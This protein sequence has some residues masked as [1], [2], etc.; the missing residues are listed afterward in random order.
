MIKVFI[1]GGTTEG[2][3]LAESL[4]AYDIQIML[5]VASSY[6]KD[7]VSASDN[8]QIVVGHDW[9]NELHKFSQ[10]Q[11]IDTLFVFDATHPFASTM[12]KKI[13]SECN[14][15][16]LKLHRINRQKIDDSYL[17]SSNKGIKINDLIHFESMDEIV[18]WLN[19]VKG[20]IYSTLGVKA[21][22]K[23][24]EIN[25][26]EERITARILSRLESLE[27]AIASGIP[28]KN[29]QCLEGPFSKD[30]NYCLFRESDAKYLITKE[31]GLAGGYIE[32]LA[33]ASDLN[34]ITLILNRPMDETGISVEAAIYLI[35]E[36]LANG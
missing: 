27:A 6:G 20:N 19:N 18:F 8:L 15:L 13:S 23:L 4:S 5:S 29:L 36:A 30:L 12:S 21:L 31:S 11:K 28:P 34:M 32:K 24:M 22:P 35:K 1:F 3:I 16:G 7:V 10:N 2:R 33:A 17:L 14:I 25:D 26:A 9:V